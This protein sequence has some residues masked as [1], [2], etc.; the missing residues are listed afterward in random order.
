MPS[1]RQVRLT[2]AG[3]LFSVAPDRQAPF[4]HP[5]QLF[6]RGVSSLVG[7]P[8]WQRCSSVLELGRGVDERCAPVATEERLDVLFGDVVES[9]AAVAVSRPG[10]F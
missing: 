9:A 10:Q 3:D 2:F 7:D 1:E 6:D 8:R 4:G 5:G